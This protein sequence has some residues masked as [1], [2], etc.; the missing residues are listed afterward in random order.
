MKRS[1]TM[2]CICVIVILFAVAVFYTGCAN[3]GASGLQSLLEE[4]PLVPQRP[5]GSEPGVPVAPAES[6]EPTTPVAPTVPATE[7]GDV[8]IDLTSMSVTMVSAQVMQILMAPEDFLGQTIRII[9]SHFSFYWEDAEMQIHYVVL[10]VTA[11]CCGQAF[12]FILPDDIVSSMGYPP[13]Y[14]IIE[15]TG[16]LSSYEKLGR[17]YYYLAVIELILW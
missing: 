12:E 10:N 14:A 8:D 1:Y 2:K 11:G 7:S 16:G 4:Q 5:P 13:Q 6:V 17:V 15:L 3:G 9:G